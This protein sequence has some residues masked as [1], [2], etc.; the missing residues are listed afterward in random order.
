MPSWNVTLSDH[1]SEEW[2]NNL[3]EHRTDASGGFKH[4]KCGG[5]RCQNRHTRTSASRKSRRR[6]QILYSWQALHP[7]DS[8]LNS[9]P[10]KLLLLA[11]ITNRPRTK[12]K[13]HPGDS[14]PSH[15][16]TLLALSWFESQILAYESP[17]S[18]F[19]SRP[20]WFHPHINPPPADGSIERV[21]WDFGSLLLS[22][23][24]GSLE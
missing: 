14:F 24:S 16:G 2:E 19:P 18:D 22:F 7:H 4:A 3:P 21:S 8:L 12:C 23:F 10:D 9:F 6:I 1:V 20:I 5:I 17:R 15:V 13:D 11:D